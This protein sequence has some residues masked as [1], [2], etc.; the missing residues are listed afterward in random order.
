MEEELMKRKT[1]CVYFLASP[2][3]C[4]K[5]IECEY[6]HNEMARLNPRDC[7]YW[8]SG[9]CL[10]PTCG[11]RHPPLEV[12]NG[13]SVGA[14]SFSHFS[15]VSSSKY[16][17]PCYFYFSGYCNKGDRCPFLHAPDNSS[18]VKVK[19]EQEVTDSP[20]SNTKSNVKAEA[21]VPPAE[22]D[23]GTSEK[24]HKIGHELKVR[25]SNGHA[26]KLAM[27]DI[28]EANALRQ[29]TASEYEA[30]ATELDSLNPSENSA[31]VEPSSCSH[32]SSED[33]VAN[34]IEREEWLESSPGFDVLVDGRSENLGYGDEDRYL[35]GLDMDHE[36]LECHYVEYD[37]EDQMDYDRRI[38]LED[39]KPE[40]PP[41]SDDHH[42]QFDLVDYF[43][44]LNSVGRKVN[45]I[46]SHK[47][48]FPTME[49]P[50]GGDYSV[51]DLRHHLR[52]RRIGD[53]LE[54]RVSTRH[55]LS[56]KTAR[57]H[58]KKL[59]K[60]GSSQLVHGRLASKVERNGVVL[61]PSKMNDV[62]I[63]AKQHEI[64]STTNL[65]RRKPTTDKG[66]KGREDSNFTGPKTLAQ[67]K[68]ERSKGKGGDF[69]GPKSLSELLREK[70]ATSV[71]TVEVKNSCA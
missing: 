69:E 64:C 34:D 21:N 58:E 53:R 57:R 8:K 65:I 38:L 51:D 43:P 4:K 55:N 1:D 68:E 28:V 7:W 60:R 23:A 10:N 12:S 61:L 6:R 67:I 2:F 18:S 48:K 46:M 37:Y 63:H 14:A 24:A 22:K 33:R 25:P 9:D 16:N 50:A 49:L 26:P 31:K 27:N 30:V 15:A 35:Q 20:A 71:G 42:Q 5:G 39:M 66:N 29:I 3:T 11:F 59:R 44:S 17:V 32:E 47:R 36:D 19:L 54:R 41:F 70:T 45:Q 52:K 62:E 56:H 40:S 13:A